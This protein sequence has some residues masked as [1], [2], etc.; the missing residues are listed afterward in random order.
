MQF[1]LKEIYK[2]YFRIGAAVSAD[3]LDSHKELILKHFNSITCENAMK[4]GIT[5]PERDKYKLEDADKIYNFAIDN[6]IAIRGHNFVWHQ[7]VPDWLF[8]NPDRE[9]LKTVLDNHIKTLA[10]RYPEVYCW[11]V[12]NEGLDDSE[13]RFYRDTPW[14]ELFGEEYFKIAFD[15]SDKYLKGKTLFYNDYNEFNPV[16]RRKYLELA[17]RLKSEGVPISGVGLQCHLG[18]NHR[19]SID[20]IKEGIELYAKLGLKLQITELDFSLYPYEDREMHTQPTFEE[21][22]QQAE[23]CKSVFRVFREYG[24]EIEAVTLWGVSDDVS[25]L[26]DFPVKGRKNGGLLFDEEQKPKECFYAICDF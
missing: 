13:E 15:I 9:L 17:E 12:I 11:D 26:N 6:G 4:F 21:Y 19:F 14:Y 24:K 5:E 2:D 25:W 18:L 22:K 3:S 16:K 8:E 23:T 10:E 7:E 1:S 20:E